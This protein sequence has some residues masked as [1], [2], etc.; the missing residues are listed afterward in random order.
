MMKLKCVLTQE[1]ASLSILPLCLLS[2]SA[3]QSQE[4]ILHLA[5]FAIYYHLQINS[6]SVLVAN[7]AQSCFNALFGSSYG[8]FLLPR[9]FRTNAF[10]LRCHWKHQLSPKMEMHKILLQCL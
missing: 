6:V 4:N 1:T 10:T 7:W 8:E 5:K 2:F 3:V 9:I